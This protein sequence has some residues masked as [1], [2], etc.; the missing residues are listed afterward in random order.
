[1]KVVEYIDPNT[2]ASVRIESL[3]IQHWLFE[4]LSKQQF[5]VGSMNKWDVVRPFVVGVEKGSFLTLAES[6]QAPQ[7]I[8]C[9]NI[10][11]VQF[12][13]TERYAETLPILQNYVKHMF[14]LMQAAGTICHSATSMRSDLSVLSSTRKLGY[15]FANFSDKPQFNNQYNVR[16]PVARGEVTPISTD[17]PVGSNHTLSAALALSIRPALDHSKFTRSFEREPSNEH[18]AN[19][20]DSN[21]TNR[22]DISS[23]SS[24]R[25]GA[26]SFTAKYT[27][28]DFLS[29]SV[30][31]LPYDP[32]QEI[33][34]SQW[35]DSSQT[36]H[37][38]GFTKK[39][40]RNYLHPF[41]SE[42]KKDDESDI[43]MDV[44][45]VQTMEKE[46]TLLELEEDMWMSGLETR[47]LP[48]IDHV[49][50]KNP[51]PF[52][53][54]G[55]HKQIEREWK[56]K[57]WLE[58]RGIQQAELSN[59]KLSLTEKAALARKTPILSKTVSLSNT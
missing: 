45:E 25:L 24:T 13:I 30:A 54:F 7:V 49:F 10:I 44:K 53:A 8:E 23:I 26:N 31:K 1:M 21:L 12:H 37:S 35:E 40:I 2:E 36:L 16:I 52:C 17:A 47:P 15:S 14:F 56:E 28:R 39:E 22:T 50:K 55:K 33:D 43:D 4:S 38:I 18:S 48:P 9:G 27:N 11:G 46:T 20:I 3:Y 58:M 19:E 57:T 41:K 34:W 51:R 5:V 6:P 32:A 59:V 42:S 29:P